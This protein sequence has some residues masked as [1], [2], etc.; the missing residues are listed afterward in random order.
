MG[1][2][3]GPRTAKGLLLA[4]AQCPDPCLLFEPKSLYRS[5][6]EVVSEDYFMLPLEKAEVVLEGTNITLIGWGAQVRVLLEVAEMAK[7]ELNIDCEVIDLLSI[8]P[9]D[10]D[11]VFNV[12]LFAL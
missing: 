1:I 2:A 3:S 10:T 12:S 7:K 11:T 6:V 5:A 8:L 4:F 9:W